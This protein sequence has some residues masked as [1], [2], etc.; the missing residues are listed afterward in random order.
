MKLPKILFFVTLLFF[1]R[2]SFGQSEYI[3]STEGDIILKSRDF[4]A[5][6][7]NSYLIDGKNTDATTICRCQIETINRAFTNKQVKKFTKNRFI[8]LN[9]LIETNEAILKKLG[10]CISTSGNSVLIQVE[11][12]HGSFLGNCKANLKS[13]SDSLKLSGKNLDDYCNCRANLIREYNY[14]DKD[15]EKLSN[16]NTD[17]Y[18]IFE[19]EC[20]RFLEKDYYKPLPILQIDG[21]NSDTLS[22]ISIKGMS[23]LNVRLSVFDDLYWLLD[24]GASDLLINKEMEE[25]LKGNGTL[26]EDNYEGIKDY[27]LANGTI[28]K[29]RT[30]MANNVKIG[31]YTL[32]NVGISVSDNGK[33][34][35]I[36]RS[37]LNKFGTITLD[38][39][40]NKIYLTK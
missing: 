22:F 26:G 35:L 36:G 37:L 6:C 32:N 29:C 7:L 28:E 2:S 10:E 9:G 25:I 17:L 34:I 31:N 11:N 12:Q 5:N 18:Y 24:T 39:N 38:N 30:Y 33:K 1:V 21:P 15:L 14:T 3:Y 19:S 8:D 4:F 13:L 23:Y 40:K 16:S 20:G 27:E